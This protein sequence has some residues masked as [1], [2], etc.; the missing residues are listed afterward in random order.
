MNDFYIGV[1]PAPDKIYFVVMRVS[2]GFIAEVCWVGDCQPAHF[3]HGSA[4]LIAIED[5]SG[6]LFSKT[7]S[8]LWSRTNMRAGETWGANHGTSVY[9]HPH[10]VRGWL[11]EKARQ[12]QAP[13]K[14]REVRECLAVIFGADAF[15]KK[16]ECPKRKNKNHS[17][18]CKVCFGTGFSRENGLL[19]PLTT[20]H[21]RD[22]FAAALFAYKTNLVPDK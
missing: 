3:F 22:A 7:N 19:A 13:K 4:S 12:N 18:D 9:V 21:H 10:D 2:E 5:P 6:V 17:S 14:D 15:D 16:K 11:G 20:P 1:D 8:L